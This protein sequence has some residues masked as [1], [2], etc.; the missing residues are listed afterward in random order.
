M[1][2]K[3][4]FKLYQKWWFWLCIVLIILIVCILIYFIMQNSNKTNSV[5]SKEETEVNKQE[6]SLLCVIWE[7]FRRLEKKDSGKN[8]TTT[9]IVDN[10]E[11][12]YV[13]DKQYYWTK[14][15]LIIYDKKPAPHLV[16]VIYNRPYEATKILEDDLIWVYGTY[17]YPLIVNAN[18]IEISE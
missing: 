12:E 7:D 10:I 17:Q 18:N 15:N 16:T 1:E 14:I 8:I 11:E 9:G 13:E 2:E 5:N 6:D 3:K 4:E